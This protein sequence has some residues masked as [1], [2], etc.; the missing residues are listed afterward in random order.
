MPAEPDRVR[1]VL[2]AEGFA[3]LP[4]RL[5]EERPQQPR[6]TVQAVADVGLFSWLRAP[7]PLAVATVLVRRRLGSSPD[8]KIDPSRWVAGSKMIPPIMPCDVPRA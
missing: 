2:E 1:E 7:S 3:P 8:T 5:D 6:P 4:R